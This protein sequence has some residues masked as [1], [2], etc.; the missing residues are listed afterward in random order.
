MTSPKLPSWIEADRRHL[1]HPYTQM[2]TAPAAIPIVKAEGV[3]LYTAD[4]RR[5]LDGISSW[6]VNIHG[7]NHPRI[8][9]A[10]CEQVG[11]L[12]QV[13]FANFTHEPAALLAQELAARA[14]GD[15][16]HVFF[17]DNGSTAVEV[18][19]KM[20][21]QYWYNRGD[22][23][24][25]TFVAIDNGFHGETFGAMALGAGSVFLQAFKD[26][27]IH[28][29]RAAG[30]DTDGSS[31]TLEQ[32]LEKNHAHIAAVVIE[33]MVQAAGGMLIWPPEFL[34]YVREVTARYNI[35]LIADEVFTGFGRTGK[36]FACEHGPIAPDFLCL[37][38]GLTAGYLP[39]GATLTTAAVYDAFLSDDRSRAFFHGHSYTGNA[40]ACR[41]GLASL[42]VFDQENCLERVQQ[43]ETLFKLR[44]QSVA[45]LPCVKSTRALGALAVI[46]LATPAAG[47][48]NPIGPQLLAAFLDRGVLLRPLGNIV[49][50]LPPYV[51]TDAQV[52]EVFDIIEEVLSV[53][54]DTP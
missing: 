26:L 50:F 23:Q 18:A 48:F 24:R 3:Y 49:Y 39:M 31:P 36:M 47:Y 46:E 25:T 21:F 17:S 4:G 20:A 42:A 9:Q 54:L 15:L 53:M 27:L 13:I 7:H 5:I 8:N 16:P 38:K 34:R 14:P 28:V 40:L 44:L 45:Q 33:P 2:Q 35:L 1:W 30:P 22:T 19:M 43:L 51:I 41:A 6:W 11:Q 10:L 32:I 29:E 37:S 52:H 12:S